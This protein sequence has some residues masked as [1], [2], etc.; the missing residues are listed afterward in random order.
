MNERLRST[1]LGSMTN[2]AITPIGESALFG[3]QGQPEHTSE[4]PRIRRCAY[5]AAIACL[6]F[7]LVPAWLN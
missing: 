3:S 4:S 7:T 1:R 6:S 2:M 5:F